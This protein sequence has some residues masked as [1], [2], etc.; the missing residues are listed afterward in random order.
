MICFWFSLVNVERIYVV[1]QETDTKTVTQS[2]KY[3]TKTDA[4]LSKDI[5]LHDSLNIFC[6]SFVYK[7]RLP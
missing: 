4:N 2:L 1:W 3:L 6:A 7:E 5:I